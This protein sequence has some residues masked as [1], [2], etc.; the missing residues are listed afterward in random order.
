MKKLQK[1]FW[2][3]FACM[4]IC[5]FSGCGTMEDGNQDKVADPFYRQNMYRAGDPQ[6]AASYTDS[7][8]ISLYV[9]RKNENGSF[10][11]V[12]DGEYLESGMHT[13]GIQTTFR[14]AGSDQIPQRVYLSD[15]A[16]NG[17]EAQFDSESGYY[18]CEFNLEDKYLT[19]PL[20]VQV[21]YPDGVASK[22][23][24]IVT[25]HEN[26]RPTPEMLVKKGL[27]VTLSADA[28]DGIKTSLQSLVPGGLTVTEFK[29]APE[30]EAVFY[31]G[32]GKVL[33]ADFGADMTLNDF[34]TNSEG[35]DTRGLQIGL[36]LKPAWIALALNFITLGGG[37]N[38]DMNPVNFDLGEM[39][40]G[41]ASS[42][43]SDSEPSATAEILKDLQLDSMLF[44]NISGNPD[45]TD[46]GFAALDIGLYA[47]DAGIV[48]QSGV[49][50]DNSPIYSWPDV[51]EDL[52]DTGMD[53]SKLKGK[54][55]DVGV[56]LSQYNLNQMLSGIMS[57]MSVDLKGA[58]IESLV[59][60]IPPSNPADQ[61]V[62]AVKVNPA[63]IAIDLSGNYTSADD[64]SQKVARFAIN[65][66]QLELYEGGNP[67]AVWSLDITME[68]AISVELIDGEMN[69]VLSMVPITD[70]LLDLCHFHVMKDD[71]GL[72]LLDHANLIPMVFATL[73]DE[74]GA[75][76]VPI[77]L[78]SYFTP[79]GDDPG[80]IDIDN[81][82]CFMTLAVD[83]IDTSSFCFISSAAF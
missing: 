22:A 4:T 14:A 59:G 61:S 55:T 6:T 2:I 10:S 41:L 8:S 53:F 49:D 73:A 62:I 70:P 56:A 21:I 7:Q 28:M 81:G 19:T 35:V 78:S 63:G 75:L 24:F 17:L 44:L 31:L 72:A 64:P 11:K 43:D 74:S 20:L 77:S 52:F 16:F 80:Q 38:M 51:T 42:D 26:L 76:K 58:L 46:S 5:I 15:G 1:G 29:P 54:N 83:A 66:L 65:D 33:G 68:L 18:V 36:D 60:L 39:I 67:R 40:G 79:D 45:M 82:N 9:W 37:L 23:K 34:Y 50:E 25:T 12:S 32:F 48:E 30:G 3:V 69:L 71:K 13:F 57:T 47:A 27:G